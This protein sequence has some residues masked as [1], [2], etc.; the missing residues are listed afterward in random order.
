VGSMATA[1]NIGLSVA[2]SAVTVTPFAFTT[3]V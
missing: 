1:M 2:T 3:Q